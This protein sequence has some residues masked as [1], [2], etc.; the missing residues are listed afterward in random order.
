M[1]HG[2]VIDKNEVPAG[3]RIPKGAIYLE[4]KLGSRISNKRKVGTAASGYDADELG[5]LYNKAAKHLKG[6]NSVDV[7]RSSPTEVPP[8]LVPQM[9]KRSQIQTLGEK[10]QA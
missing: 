6:D 8:E 9:E 7:R 2:T 4:E 3:M 5:D 10:R 1:F